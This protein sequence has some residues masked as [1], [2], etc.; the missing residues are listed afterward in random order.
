MLVGII[1]FISCRH[2]INE[3][4][5]E[6]MQ[7]N[8]MVLWG[9]V[10]NNLNGKNLSKIDTIEYRG[11]EGAAVENEGEQEFADSRMF[12]IWSG[13][14]IIMKSDT[15]F[16]PQIERQPLG[17]HDL[18]YHHDQ[19]RVYT[20]S[21]GQGAMV[22][23]IGEKQ[24]LR[25]EL[26]D[27]ILVDLFIP[28]LAIVP[29]IM[30]A[31]WL[32]IRRG[33]LPIKYLVQQIRERNP[34]DLTM[35][36]ADR[37]P[38]DLLPLG[39]SINRL[40][41]KLIESISAER[42]FTDHAAHQLRTPL[43]GERLLIQTLKTI[44][45]KR[46]RAQVLADLE[47]TNDRASGLVQK[48]LTM[49][50]LSHQRLQLKP[51]LLYEAVAKELASL[52]PI[53]DKKSVELSLD[54]DVHASAHVDETMLSLILH[55]LIENAVKYAP[56]HSKVEVRVFSTPDRSGFEVRDCGPGIVPEERE[57]VFN[58]FYRGEDNPEEGAGLGLAI[59]S[60]CLVRLNG[61]ISLDAPAE[62]KGLNVVVWFSQ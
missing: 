22:I 44:E 29:L 60:E 30:A 41:D 37:L 52:G 32:G 55:N 15:A 23:E 48:L 28:L 56:A 21:L 25:N 3:V 26:V 33:M 34:D 53:A 49:A 17:F 16:P 35:I 51:I 59:V 36:D 46:D 47:A 12:R 6:R 2:E 20:T 61:Q 18:T 7:D 11:A 31:L 50:R 45:N 10:K 54:G 39:N 38:S 24:A 27:A 13:K 43:A 19:W 40:F 57:R 1:A 8:A 5:D 58:R 14:R 4:S 9:L 62:G 42:R